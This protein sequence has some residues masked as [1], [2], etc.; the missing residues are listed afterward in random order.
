VLRSIVGMSPEEAVWIAIEEAA[1]RGE[2]IS[3]QH[4]TPMIPTSLS[5]EANS[6][7]SRN[8]GSQAIDRKRDSLV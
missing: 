5:P 2:L 1:A 3:L 7:S 4:R 6:S 8:G